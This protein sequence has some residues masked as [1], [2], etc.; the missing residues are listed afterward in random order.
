[1]SP[2]VGAEII[3]NPSTSLTIENEIAGSDVTISSSGQ[4][5]SSY[6]VGTVFTN[7]YV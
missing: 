7:V 5:S 3:S 6:Q 4:S 1:M 2:T